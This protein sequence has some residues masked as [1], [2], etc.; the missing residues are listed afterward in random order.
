MKRRLRII[1]SVLIALILVGGVYLYLSGTVLPLLGASQSSVLPQDLSPG[2][3][4]KIAEIAR[5]RCRLLMGKRRESCYDEILL[6]LVER[7]EVHLAMTSLSRLGQLDQGVP[8]MGHDY[9]HV[10]GINAWSPG[11]DI[12]KIYDQCTELYQSGCYHGVIQSYLAENGIDSATV[13]GLCNQI[14]SVHESLWLRFQCVHG[15]GHGLVQTNNMHLPRALKGCDRLGDR[16]DAES[17][18]GG[19]FM[20]FIVGGRGQS[21]HPHR[22]KSASP[23][24]VA[25]AGHEGDEHAGHDMSQMAPAGSDSFKVRDPSDP[26]Y[27]CSVLDNRYLRSCYGMQAGLIIE[28]TGPDFGKIAAACDGAPPLARPWCYQG[29]GTYVSGFTVRNTE[30]SIRLC[31][32]GNPKYKAWCFVGVVKNY[33]DVTSKPADGFEFCRQVAE[34]A[35]AV[36]CYVAVGEQINVLKAAPADREALC[37][38][39]TADFQN[40]CRYGAR[41]ETARPPELGPDT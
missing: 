19:A 18:Y 41:V 25:A 36:A 6:A 23:G 5:D 3:S 14:P 20:E 39:A 28:Q 8:K 30:E 15:L 24:A 17:C 13:G 4:V 32:M 21:H 35:L 10:V 12:G 31:N 27:P 29:I 7:G 40:A 33:V 37:A 38:T 2:D 22:A 34:R 26:L 16:W 1:G 11:K 9:T